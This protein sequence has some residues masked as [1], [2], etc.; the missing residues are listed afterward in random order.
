MPACRRAWTAR[1]P[2]RE[3]WPEM[4]TTATHEALVGGALA[5]Q[6]AGR[7]G[8]L[9]AVRSEFTKIRSV[10]STYWT[11]LALVLACVGIGA[12]F[13]WG[14]TERLLRIESGR[15]FSGGQIPPGFATHIANEIR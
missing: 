10:R 9:G 3:R 7:A 15:R 2:T 4:A 6:P 11:L 8:F 12:L 14:Q 1:R 13:S 5:R